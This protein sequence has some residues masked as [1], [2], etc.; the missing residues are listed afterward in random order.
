M[1]SEPGAVMAEDGAKRGYLHT[2]IVYIQKEVVTLP[3]EREVSPP[4]ELSGRCDR[5]APRVHRRGAKRAVRLGRGEM[6]LDIKGVVDCGVRERNFCAEPGL[7]N[8][9]ILRSLRRVG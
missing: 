6:A 2:C 3:C 5:G 7:L 8:R 4:Q 1:H 9:C